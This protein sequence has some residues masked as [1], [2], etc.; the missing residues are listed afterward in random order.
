MKP[1]INIK[2]G[3]LLLLKYIDQAEV[4]VALKDFDMLEVEKLL[5]DGWAPQNWKDY[6]PKVCGLVE[7][8]QMNGY[9]A[10]PAHRSINLGGYDIE[11]EESGDVTQKGY[12]DV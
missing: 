12:G 7:Y 4:F 2:A 6:R 9:I 1:E 3:E 5:R 11:I 10:L 8:L